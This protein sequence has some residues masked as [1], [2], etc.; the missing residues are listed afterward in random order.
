MDGLFLL[1][2]T[3]LGIYGGAYADTPVMVGS[4][5]CFAS[6]VFLSYFSED[7][8][9]WLYMLSTTLILFGALGGL[10]WPVL[11]NT[12]PLIGAVVAALHYLGLDGKFIFWF[13][14]VRK[15]ESK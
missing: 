11:R 4:A 10:S 13:K 5:F 9:L 7:R 1:F 15:N 8:D 2:G 6:A 3:I 14:K 12:F